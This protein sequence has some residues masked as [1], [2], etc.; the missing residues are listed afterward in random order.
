M[1]GR[2]GSAA[3]RG[4][5]G[6][7]GGLK[8]RGA[9]ARAWKLW[10]ML[11]PRDAEHI[12]RAATR[13]GEGR[14]VLST[15]R[16]DAEGGS[17]RAAPPLWLWPV[18]LG[19][20]FVAYAPALD[21]YFIA[22]DFNWVYEAA[23]TWEHPTN[24]FSL[25]IAN[26]FRPVVHVWFAVMRRAVGVDATAYYAA[27]IFVHG[28]NGGLVAWAVARLTRDRLAGGIAGLCFVVHFTHFDAVYWLSA[29]SDVVGTSL[30]VLA[31]VSA[32]AAAQGDRREGW[33]A[34]VLTPLI[35]MCKESMVMVVPLLGWTLWCYREPAARWR[36]H[37]PW[38]G[39]AAAVWVAY[40]VMQRSFQA[41]SPHVTTGYFA[42]GLHPPRMLLNALVNFL[43]PN[44]YVVPAPW[45]VVLPLF[46]ALLAGG[47]T[48]CTWLRPGQARRA[49]FFF[50]WMVLAFV[51]CSFFQNYD[52]IPSRYSYLPSVAFAGLVGWLGAAW[53]RAHAP[54]SW[55]ARAGI[56]AV[57]SGLGLLN[58]AYVWRIDGVRYERHSRVSQGVIWRMLH[59]QN[60][61]TPDTTVVAMNV[62]PPHRGLHFLPAVELFTGR[63]IGDFITVA[64]GE[65]VPALSGD[66]VLRYRWN[67]ARDQLEPAAGGAP[68]P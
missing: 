46:A 51:P 65:P 15:E 17:L 2:D 21:N 44:R 16:P 19:L 48:L 66:R 28:L 53:W 68:H 11:A 47:W 30:T 24:V 25:V 55:R 43:I 18:T 6:R 40:L 29:I 56:L 22:D 13:P 1:V 5:G 52:R 9:G 20:A 14:R 3:A 59:D 26:F 45:W 63:P 67:S 31:I 34:L 8:G 10:G 39:P 42:L 38:L 12:T 7:C 37:L 41:D 61:L 23:R 60:A 49:L 57:V 27:A 50:G 62:G 64:P 35:L 32:A 33:T 36:Q 4:D 58:I 54:V